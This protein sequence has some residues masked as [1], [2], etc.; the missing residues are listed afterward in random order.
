MANKGMKYGRRHFMALSATAALA[1]CSGIQLPAVPVKVDLS[2]ELT[3]L[4]TDMNSI[5]KSV[6][7]IALPASV[8]GWVE[9]IRA[10]VSAVASSKIVTDAKAGLVDISAAWEAIK[11]YIPASVS[12]IV[13]AVETVLPWALKIAGLVSMF[14]RTRPTGMSLEQAR[15]VLRS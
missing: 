5:Y 14:A 11:P 13:A 9:K 8:S 2:P 10:G 7:S 3:E 15:A 12:K 1:G 4:I 6:S